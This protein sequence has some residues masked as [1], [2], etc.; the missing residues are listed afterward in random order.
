MSLRSMHKR[1]TRI[2][3][4]HNYENRRKSFC[5]FNFSTEEKMF[6]GVPQ[7][8]ELVALAAM[9]PRHLCSRSRVSQGEAPWLG[10]VQWLGDWLM[11]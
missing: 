8:E 5:S 1:W 6:A 7:A 9:A 2:W 10:L 4:A 11:G 3:R